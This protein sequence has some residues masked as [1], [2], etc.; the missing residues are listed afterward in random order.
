MKIDA[1]PSRPL[2]PHFPVAQAIL[3]G[4][5]DS[6]ILLLKA[7]NKLADNTGGDNLIAIIDHVIQ[8]Q[9]HAA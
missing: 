7:F 9:N 6:G 5:I 4:W 1:A 8:H 2:A 3:G